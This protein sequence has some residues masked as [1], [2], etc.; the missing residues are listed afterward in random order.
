VSFEFI[1]L[2]LDILVTVIDLETW[3]KKN[4]IGKT[5]KRRLCPTSNM[6]SVVV[7]CES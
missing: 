7:E 5:L 6:L 4:V 1:S 2:E 3:E